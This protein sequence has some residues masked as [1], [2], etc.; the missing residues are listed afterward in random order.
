MRA[1]AQAL[2]EQIWEPL[3]HRDGLKQLPNWNARRVMMMSFL[4]LSLFLA[5]YSKIPESPITSIVPIEIHTHSNTNNRA[6]NSTESK[7]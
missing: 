2:K 5:G 1:L 3:L 7:I 6:N 4:T